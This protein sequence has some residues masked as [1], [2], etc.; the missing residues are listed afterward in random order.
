[1]RSGRKVNHFHLLKCNE[2]TNLFLNKEISIN[3]IFHVQKINMLPCNIIRQLSQL[4]YNLFQN[5]RIEDLSNFIK[6]INACNMLEYLWIGVIFFD[7]I[8]IGKLRISF[9]KSLR[10]FHCGGINHSFSRHGHCDPA[11]IVQNRKCAED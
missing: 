8:R 10:L 5:C 4:L 9:C 2:S 7:F 3:Q 6:V 1:M 11:Y